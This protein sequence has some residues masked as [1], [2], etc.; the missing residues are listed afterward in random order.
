MQ[1]FE[2]AS[3][4]ASGK[5]LRALFA[6]LLIY[7]EIIDVAAIGDTFVTHFCDDLP[8][9]LW[10]WP[11]ILKH[12]TNPHYDYGLY[13]FHQLLKES[14]KTLDQCGLL[15]PTHTWRADNSLL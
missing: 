7:G 14:G 9:Q 15:L 2:E 4:F 8:H 13:L 10:N 6:T 3:L 11:N 5:S 12:L 1:Y